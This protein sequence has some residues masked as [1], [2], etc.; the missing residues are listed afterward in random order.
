MRPL[1]ALLIC[2]AAAAT[3]DMPGWV[4]PGILHVET[5][6]YYAEDGHIVYVNQQRGSHGE[7]GAFQCTR[8]AFDQ[9]KYPGESFWQIETDTD[10][11]E[12]IAIRYLFWLREHHASWTKVV[13]AYNAGPHHRSR[14][15]EQAVRHDGEA[16]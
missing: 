4:L 7:I 12:T 9:V 5:R 1:L 8:R 10:F 16:P 6:S 14:A 3:E 15:Y 13:G 2:A 11:A